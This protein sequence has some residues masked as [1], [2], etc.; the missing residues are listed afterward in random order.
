MPQNSRNHQDPRFQDQQ[1]TTF[2][3][4]WTPSPGHCQSL[5][6]SFCF[7][8]FQCTNSCW[9]SAWS[10]LSWS[11]D[12]CSLLVSPDSAS[13]T[14]SSSRVYYPSCGSQFLQTLTPEPRL[15]K[16]KS[17]SSSFKSSKLSKSLLVQFEL[18]CFSWIFTQSS[19]TL[20]ASVIWWFLLC[21]WCGTCSLCWW[22]PDILEQCCVS[23]DQEV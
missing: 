6:C 4:V 21:H 3:Q 20:V 23:Q 12:F 2:C 15:S 11:C 9:R 14:S 16:I 5:W 17:K 1:V 13:C 22:I 19:L 8:C 18:K 10:N 7:H